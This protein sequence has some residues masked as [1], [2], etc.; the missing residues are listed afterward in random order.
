MTKFSEHPR[1]AGRPGD[2]PGDR[3]ADRPGG[4][5]DAR[6]AVASAPRQPDTA[7]PPSPPA[8][9]Q[10]AI[11]RPGGG[12]KSNFIARYFKSRS[13]PL[14]NLA[15]L[16][17][18]LG[19]VVLLG[20]QTKLFVVE[21]YAQHD[22]YR[23]YLAGFCKL[24]GC[25][26]PPRQ[27]ASRCT[28]T[29]AKI[30]PHPRQPGALMVTAKLVNEAIFAQP[31]PDVLLTLTDR[32]GRV[33]GRRTYPPA[34]YLSAGQPAVLASGELGVLRFALA[35]PHEKAVGFAVSIAPASGGR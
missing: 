34:V 35:G 9:G 6:T 5:V 19:L 15:W 10:T 30:T 14:G 29:H 12:K 31:Y 16:V 7:P 33:V 18:A 32:D 23:P 28:L 24:A 20:W 11:S 27:D 8:G 3:P 26:L 1:P 22:G 13:N 2:R 17:A 25:Q 21:K 4:H